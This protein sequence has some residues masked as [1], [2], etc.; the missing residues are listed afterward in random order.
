MAINPSTNGTMTGRVTAPNAD[1]PYGSSQDETAPGN[2][3]GTPYFKARA[4]DI[5]GLLQ[6]LLTQAAIVPSGNADT[7]L[8]S[9]YGDALD[10]LFGRLSDFA[11]SLT[12]VGYQKFPG[13]LILQWGAVLMVSNPEAFTLPI[14]FP[15]AGLVGLA[16]DRTSITEI[17]GVAALSTTQITLE[18]AGLV[19]G[20]TSYLAIG[21]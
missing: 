9:D 8:A 15:N 21:W 13:G 3:D 18:S 6:W 20:Q 2:N 16:S 1:Y 5:F 14:A 11:N 4:D 17:V 7:V 19:P 10:A 12:A